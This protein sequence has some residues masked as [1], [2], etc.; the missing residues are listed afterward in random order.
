MP[1][2]GKGRA[3]FQEAL[4]IKAEAN[5][6]MG[7]A[8]G[9]ELKGDQESAMELQRNA[10]RKLRLGLALQRKALEEQRERLELRRKTIDETVIDTSK[11]PE[12]QSGSR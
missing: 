1:G 11:Y 6:E 5:R 2:I 9:R 12:S 3:K 10:M 8:F 7:E 4:N